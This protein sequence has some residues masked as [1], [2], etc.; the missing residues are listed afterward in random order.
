M[1][2][3]YGITKKFV[4]NCPYLALSYAGTFINMNV[5]QNIQILLHK[6]LIV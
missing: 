3:M 4:I 6:P 1:I 2:L 5:Q